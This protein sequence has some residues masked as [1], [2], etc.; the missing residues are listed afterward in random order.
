MKKTFTLLAAVAMMSSSALAASV[1]DV[2]S[3]FDARG[4]DNSLYDGMG[5]WSNSVAPNRFTFEALDG[6]DLSSSATAKISLYCGDE[7]LIAIGTSSLAVDLYLGEFSIDLYSEIQSKES[8]EYRLVIDDDYLTY[9][10]ESVTG[11]TYSYTYEN[12]GDDTEPKEVDFTYVLNPEAGATVEKLNQIELTFPAYVYEEKVSYN[13]IGNAVASLKNENGSIDF[14]SYWP[15]INDN[16]LIFNFGNEDTQWPAGEYTFTIY[17]NMVAVDMRDRDLT[18]DGNFEGLSVTYTVTGFTPAP[19]PELADYISLTFPTSLECNN[20]NTATA[21]NPEGGMCF[22]KFTVKGDIKPAPAEEWPEYV[23]LVYNDSE[24]FS[25]N[26][27]DELE[28]QIVPISGEGEDKVSEW[29]L[30]ANT[31]EDW[32]YSVATYQR[33]G[34]YVLQF[35]NKTFL[36]NGEPMEGTEFTFEYSVK[37]TAVDMIEV[38]ESY[39]VYTIDGRVAYVGEDKAAIDTLDAG[40]YIVNGK[41]V[42]LTK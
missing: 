15:E 34:Q 28:F 3:D 35:P 31:D 2:L 39:I 10:G 27:N 25:I 37:P 14:S 13:M 11:G 42:I 1:Y 16:T 29:I 26:P 7:L 21:A 9:N 17:P 41:K 23:M 8:G 4:W 32:G 36:L 12:T 40:L 20:E 24:Y 18:A 5:D 19:R 6:V 33:E 22:F 30:R 38:A